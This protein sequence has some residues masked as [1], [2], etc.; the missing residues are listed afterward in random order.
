[1]QLDFFRSEQELVPNYEWSDSKIC[2]SCNTLKP[3][4]NY[5]KH[6]GHKDNLDG[7]CRE[8]VNAQVRLRKDLRRIAPPKPDR[9]SCCGKTSSD[10]VLDHCHTDHT[11]RGWLCRHCNAGIGFL[12]DST[13]GLEKA[14]MYLRKHDERS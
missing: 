7:R 14:L 4:S 13:E 12:N 10:I 3:K 5:S 9:C 1:M 6:T 11:F 2:I 8:C